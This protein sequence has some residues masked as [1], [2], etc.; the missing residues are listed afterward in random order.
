MCSLSTSGHQAIANVCW[1]VLQLCTG[2][3]D[4]LLLLFPIRIKNCGKSY[5]SYTHSVGISFL[6][7]GGTKSSNL[8]NI[9]E[10]KSLITVPFVDGHYVDSYYLTI[11]NTVS[12][13]I[14]YRGQERSTQIIDTA[15]QDE[16]SILTSKH[17]VDNYGYMI[18]YSVSSRQSFEMARI[19]RYVCSLF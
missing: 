14:M 10:E 7:D 19:I 13:V 4:R 15:G 3:T 1:M 17:L 18:V 6:M 8:T 11:E 9:G 12:E 2:S 16:Y 5:L